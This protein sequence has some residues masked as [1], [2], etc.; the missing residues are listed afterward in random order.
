MEEEE[1][2]EDEEEGRGPGNASGK[3]NQQV[4]SAPG[5]RAYDDDN[6]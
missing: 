5:V 6:K 1:E 4:T 2:E 3:K